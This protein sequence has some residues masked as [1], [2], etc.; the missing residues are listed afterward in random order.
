[1]RPQQKAMAPEFPQFKPIQLEDRDYI[2]GI[3]WKYQPQTSEFSFTNLFIWRSYYGIQWSMYQDW[4][5]IL[6]TAYTNDFY[7]LQPIGPPS[8][9]EVTLMIL[10][11]LKKE[12]GEKEPR[13]ELADQRLVSEIEGGTE[14]L[15]EPIRD[16]FDYVYRSEDLIYLEGRKYHAK[17]NYI[18]RFLN[19]CSFTY[20]SLADEHIESC[21]EVS[22]NWYKLHPYQEDL[23]LSGERDAIR[24]VLIHFRDLKIQGG[25]ILSGAKVE[26]FTLG[27][28][29][30]EQT[31]VVHIEKA[32]PEIPGLY[33]M[34]NQQFCERCWQNVPYINRE[35]DLGKEGLR[36]AKL[37]Y[38]P[39][40]LVDKFMIRFP[41]V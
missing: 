6:C 21:L 26:A 15:I 8:R 14:L 13:I 35:Q 25:V 3:F 38:Y 34:I 16:H 4:L 33:A 23:N 18:K 22:D 31:M 39:D 11:W 41:Q 2:Q 37:S 5:I 36:K 19:S 30:N 20:I 29:L 32:N 17:R 24:E 9:L 12:K 28:L 7:A 1:M 27:E 10:Q 40:H